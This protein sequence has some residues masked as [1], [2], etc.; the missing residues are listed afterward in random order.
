MDHGWP[1]QFFTEDRRL[2]R[3]ADNLF[4]TL[5]ATGPADPA[6]GGWVR[7]F[8]HA[9]AFRCT[10]LEFE[11][12]RMSYIATC[13]LTILYISLYIIMIYYVHTFVSMCVCVR[14][15]VC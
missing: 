10:H 1:H 8:A 5:Y 15:L 4:A 13:N 2:R 9:Y 3:L 11:S 14:L 6:V 12:V 7:A